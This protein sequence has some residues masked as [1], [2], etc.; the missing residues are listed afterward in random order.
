M[1]PLKS[2]LPLFLHAALANKQ[3]LS[4]L[5]TEMTQKPGN[6]GESGQKPHRGLYLL[7]PDVAGA[8]PKAAESQIP[9]LDALGWSP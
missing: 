2:C 9:C 5:G 3:A 7:L 4:D 1:P 8:V 6:L